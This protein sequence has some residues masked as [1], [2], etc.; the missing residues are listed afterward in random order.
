M[1][2]DWK[3]FDL[4]TVIAQAEAK[5][6]PYYEFLRVRDLSLGI[7]R[8]PAGARDL[9]A[10]HDE[11]EVYY[12]VA[13]RAVVEVDGTVREVGPGSLLYVAPTTEHSFVDILE[14]MTLLV[15]FASGGG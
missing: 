14:D 2:V 1:A 7:Y 13:G 12:L 5:E 3:A 8:L 6:L 15:F 11:A 10:P 4:A 9:Q